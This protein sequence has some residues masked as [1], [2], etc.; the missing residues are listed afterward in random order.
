M[1]T[2]IQ[3]HAGHPVKRDDLFGVAGVFGGKVRTC[4]AL[5]QGAPGLVTAGARHSPQISIVARVAEHM[6]IPAWCYTATGPCT[7]EIEDAEAHGAGVYRV[8]PGYNSVIAARAREAAADLGWAHVPFGMEHPMAV[9][10]TRSQ[11]ANVVSYLQAHPDTRRI[12]VPVG[13]GMSLAGILHGLADNG[14][15][16]PV[17]G[18][19]VGARPERRLEKY[20]PLMWQVQCQL[21]DAGAPYQQETDGRMGDLVL[22]PIYEAKCLAHLL[23]GDLLW[24]V[25]IRGT[26]PVTLHSTTKETRP[27]AEYRLHRQAVQ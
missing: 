8:K 16:V 2:P 13:S 26:M 4:Q 15:E 14:S 3:E 21:V 1:L 19:V 17:V 20:A 23:P 22:D 11:V 24:V 27:D 7:A 25:G 5:A 12:V 18:V 10:Q 9:E 6:G